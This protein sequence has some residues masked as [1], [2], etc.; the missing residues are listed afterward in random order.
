MATSSAH[1]QIQKTLEC[2]GVR[3][4]PPPPIAEPSTSG[5][6]DG[7]A[8]EGDATGGDAAGGIP[9][10]PHPEPQVEPDK[11]EQG[12]EWDERTSAPKL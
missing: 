5:K 12:I 8:D 11:L 4:R 6:G 9:L 1:P 2:F 10:D 3:A 7:R